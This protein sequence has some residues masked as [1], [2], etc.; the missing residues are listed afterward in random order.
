MHFHLPRRHRRQLLFPPGLLALAGLLWLGCVAVGTLREKLAKRSIITLF[1]PP[2]HPDSDNFLF[3]KP[4]PL[5]L[6]TGEL[7]KFRAWRDVYFNGQSH[8][9]SINLLK[10]DRAVIY[11]QAHAT[12]D[13]GIRVCFGPQAK[14]VNL[15]ATL[16]SMLK[17]GVQK[18]WL[19]V[20]HQPTAFYAF[21]TK[22]DVKRPESEFTNFCGTNAAMVHY[23]PQPLATYWSASYLTRF[24]HW[25]AALWN[26][27]LKSTTWY[28][29]A[30]GTGTEYD[31]SLKLEMHYLPQFLH[32]FWQSDWRVQFLLI[33]GMVAINCWK[34]K[35]Q[36]QL[37]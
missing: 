3:H 18:Y 35:R 23:G 11:M 19:D 31:I 30:A 1:V 5:A 2:T 22:P 24:G 16:N 28:T 27:K 6:S 14:Y 10:L 7:N 25:L 32:D 20:K 21:T 15:V 26:P 8:N 12:A 33:I 4:S 13:N 36:L 34:L 9:D 29:S 37:S 17:Y